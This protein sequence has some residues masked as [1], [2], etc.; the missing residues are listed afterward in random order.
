MAKNPKARVVDEDGYDDAPDSPQQLLSAEDRYWVWL[1]NLTGF[2]KKVWAFLGKELNPWRFLPQVPLHGFV[3][4][5]YS[6]E[7]HVC[8]EADGPDHAYRI[9]ALK[10][11]KRDEVLLAHGIRTIRIT[12][13]EFHTTKPVQLYDKIEAFFSGSADGS[14]RR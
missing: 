14:S 2:E 8:L 1:R 3:L 9:Q 4:D 10:D 12:L 5:F 7:G 11:L 13:K 6:P